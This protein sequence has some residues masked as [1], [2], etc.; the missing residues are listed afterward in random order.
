MGP[1]VPLTFH[2][3]KKVLSHN[4]MKSKHWR[5]YARH[6]KEWYNHLEPFVYDLKGL[7]LSWSSWEII[8][9]IR[10]PCRE[11]DAA[12]LVGGTKPIP[13][14]LQRYGVIC[15]DSPKHFHCDYFQMGPEE[16]QVPDGVETILRLTQYRL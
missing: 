3:R 7:G 4:F 9:V 13:D 12:N 15:D 14:G 2:L 11:F 16:A 1:V 5:L 8:R 10:P 6:V